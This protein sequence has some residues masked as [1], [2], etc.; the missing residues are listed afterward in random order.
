MSLITRTGTIFTVFLCSSSL[1]AQSWMTK[2]GYPPDARVLIVNASELGVTWETNLAVQKLADKGDL[3]SAS[4]VVVGPWSDSL[5]R[6]FQSQDSLDIG[7]SI[8]LTNPYSAMHWR[9]LTSE[10]GPTSL[11]D[12]NGMPWKNVA[13][14]AVNVDAQDVKRELDAQIHRAKELGL[15]PTH[16]CAFYGT[17]YSRPDLAAVLLGASRKYWLPAPV[18]DLTPEMAEKFRRHGVPVDK[19]MIELVQSYPFPKLDDFQIVPSGSTYEE[20][21]AKY[22]ESLKALRPGLTQI[23]SRPAVGSEGLKILTPEWQQRV[24]DAQLIS[25]PE[26]KSSMVEA[27]IIQT[28]WRELMHRFEGKREITL[29]PKEEQATPQ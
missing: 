17:I 28:D 22:L 21:R 1:I 10:Q 2:L 18:V 6:W 5:T 27:G 9:L 7:V 14:I 26:V 19:D 11:V 16:I 3:R 4:V 13:Q 12:A 25:D 8:A 24:W 20:K 29:D 15:R 23:I